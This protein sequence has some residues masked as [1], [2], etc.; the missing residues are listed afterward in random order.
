RLARD[1]RVHVAVSLTAARDDLRDR[2]MPINKRYPLAELM[3]ACKRLELPRRKRVTL[4]YVLLGGVNDT[5]RDARELIALVH[6]IPVK[7]NLIPFNPFPGSGF[8]RPDDATVERFQEQM[9]AA[10][11]HAT[12]RKSRGRDID[13]ACGQLATAGGTGSAPAEPA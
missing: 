5:A 9:L 1:T 10:G 2:L 13:A 7:L 4:E 3:A 12:V 11:V 6:D 8:E